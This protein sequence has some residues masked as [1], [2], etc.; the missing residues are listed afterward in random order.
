M[1]IL[2]SG[3]MLV[4]YDRI[5]RSTDS[6]R[7]FHAVPGTANDRL[8]GGF[9]S[10][11]VGYAVGHGD[12]VYYGEYTTATRPQSVRVVRGTA[13]GQVWHI[14]H[15]FAPGDVFHIHSITYDSTRR[16]FWIAAGDVERE[17]RLAYTD[18]H[19]RSIVTAGCCHQDWRLVDMIVTRS[20]LYWGSDDDRHS[21]GIFRYDV[22]CGTLERVATLDN[23]SYH[24][25]RTADGTFAITTT[26]EPRSPFTRRTGPPAATSLWLSSEG[27][28]W[29]QVR[30]WAGKPDDIAE[31]YRP[32]LQLPHGDPLPALFATPWF[33]T[34]DEFAALRIRVRP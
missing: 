26:Y 33:T 34:S 21:P 31:G 1:L 18:D 29:E 19:F 12:T 13:D 14:A 25:A 16:R 4:F 6:G 27:R 11:S 5:Y 28:H 15:T 32:Q 8:P 24:A 20:A 7:S 17:P 2:R 9:P 3:T 10:S 23:P 22:D 30:S